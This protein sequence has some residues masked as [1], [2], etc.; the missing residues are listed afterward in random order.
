[1]APRAV[2]WGM[3]AGDMKPVVVAVDGPAGAGKSSVAKLLARRLGLL[4]DR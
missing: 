3:M 2:N 1:M 4:I